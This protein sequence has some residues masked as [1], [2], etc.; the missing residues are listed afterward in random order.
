MTVPVGR[1]RRPPTAQ[2]AVLAELRRSIRAGDLA[3]GTQIVQDALAERLGVSRVPVR[4]ALRI[5]EGEGQIAYEPHRGYFVAALDLDEL[6]EIRRI[7]DLLEP[8]AV[9]ASIPRLEDEDVQR[10]EEAFDAMESAAADGDI[11]GMNGAHTRFHFALYDPSGM[12]RLVRILRQLWDMSD[13][14][15]AVY[16]GDEEYRRTAQLEHRDILSLAHQRDTEALVQ[17]LEEHRRR[18]VDRLG[19]TLPAHPGRKTS[20]EPPTGASTRRRLTRER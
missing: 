13:P 16:H 15:R 6:S 8:E 17:L 10:M 3:P 19:E 1:F 2:Q 11:T 9:R 14:Y 12:S 18:T 20:D 4:E 7:R 5:L